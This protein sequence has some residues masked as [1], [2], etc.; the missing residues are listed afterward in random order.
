MEK[1]TKIIE[2]N[3]K[4]KFVNI[5]YSNNKIRTMMI[6]LFIKVMGNDYEVMENGSW[7]SLQRKAKK[8]KWLYY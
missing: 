6:I 3:R 5:H 7:K 8:E 2:I 1:I 4:Y